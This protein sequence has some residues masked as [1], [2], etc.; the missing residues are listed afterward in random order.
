MPLCGH[1]YTR[2][3]WR[4]VWLSGGRMSCTHADR[5]PCGPQVDLTAYFRLDLDT[6]LN[7][8]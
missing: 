1:G 8:I 5:T 6:H 4:Q 7:T 2:R 3:D